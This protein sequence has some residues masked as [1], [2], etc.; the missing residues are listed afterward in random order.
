MSGGAVFLNFLREKLILAEK[1]YPSRRLSPVSNFFAVV[2]RWQTRQKNHIL[3]SK[4][5]H[6]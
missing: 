4:P 6:R 5:P 1:N 3:A 2:F